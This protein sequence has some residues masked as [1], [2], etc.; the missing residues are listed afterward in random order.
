[1]LLAAGLL[2]LVCA[3]VRID[4]VQYLDC[5]NEMFR[6][7]TGHAPKFV[8]PNP[9]A[10]RAPAVGTYNQAAIRET[11]GRSFGHSVVPA[12]PLPPHNAGVFP[13]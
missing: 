1:M 10:A 6:A 7:T 9:A 12:R 4:Q 2:G 13:R 11:L 5:L 8:L 3:D